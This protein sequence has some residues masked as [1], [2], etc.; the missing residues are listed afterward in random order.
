MR[1][2]TVAEAAART[3]VAGTAQIRTT[4]EF[5]QDIGESDFPHKGTIDFAQRRA[6]LRW[7]DPPGDTT[8]T[9]LS[10]VDRLYFRR[11]DG[12][13]WTERPAGLDDDRI[14]IIVRLL[15]AE[16]RSAGGSAVVRGQ[17]CTAYAFHVDD[18]SVDGH[19][20]IDASR[21]IRRVVWRDP[22]IPLPPM[23]PHVGWPTT[24]CTVELWD[25]G[26]PAPIEL[27]PARHVGPASQ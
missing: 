27:P 14:T 25:F 26:A 6:L 9:H 18:S 2:G 22:P 16:T 19:A 11:R 13:I 7:D 21:R 15:G 3:L 1:S 4:M 23:P 5:E 20:W 10:T 17:R 8:K 24:T 12:W